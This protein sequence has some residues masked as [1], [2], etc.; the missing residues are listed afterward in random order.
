MAE[1]ISRIDPNLLAQIM[2][3]ETT[4]AAPEVGQPSAASPEIKSSGMT[5]DDILGKA[6]NALDGVSNVENDANLMMEKYMKGQVDVSDV[7]I[8]TAKMNI[9]VQLAVATVTSAVN[10]FKEITQMQI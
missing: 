7:M 10:T 1:G 5:F 3:P 4:P 9:A 6:V 2:G 8:A